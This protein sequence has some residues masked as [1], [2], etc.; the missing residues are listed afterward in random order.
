MAVRSGRDSRRVMDLFAVDKL[1]ASHDAAKAIPLSPNS[2]RALLASRREWLAGLLVGT[3]A[4]SR[5]SPAVG[6]APQGPIARPIESPKLTAAVKL[7]GGVSPLDFEGGDIDTKL[8]QAITHAIERIEVL[9]LRNLPVLEISRPMILS[10]SVARG[11]S[12][13]VAPKS[14]LGGGTHIVARA[15]MRCMVELRNAFGVVL[16][17]L[18]LDGRNQ[19]QMLLDTSWRIS[20]APAMNCRWSDLELRG[21]A[22]RVSWNAD[23]NNDCDFAFIQIQGPTDQPSH[24]AINLECGGGDL[25]LFRVRSYWGK[26]IIAAQSAT[27]T[28]CVT[29]GVVLIGKDFN[30]L[31]IAGGYHYP[32]ADTGMNI[33][34]A[35]RVPVMALS[36]HGAHV[37]NGREGGVVLGGDGLLYGGATFTQCHVFSP[38]GARGVRLLGPSVVGS[39]GPGIR[40]TVR[41]IGGTYQLVD[42]AE[43]AA[44]ALSCEGVNHD[45]VLLSRRRAG[46][47]LR[48]F[49]D[50]DAGLYRHE[51]PAWGPLGAM[52]SASTGE[53]AGGG[54]VRLPL[55]GWP[56]T[57]RLFIRSSDDRCP[58]ATFDYDVTSGTITRIASYGAGQIVARID[59]GTLILSHDIA[60]ATTVF[61]VAAIG[62]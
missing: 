45:Q 48:V 42:L 2:L 17:G 19:A 57:G 9:D 38:G 5:P 21:A 53:C 7:R 33:E 16:Q 10:R 35:G 8:D 34:L 4:A 26:L 29:V 59:A 15:P 41:L 1:R 25:S 13:W 32:A 36:V 51:H 6:A 55:A 58:R 11:E 30:L 37:E 3:V 14:V 31:S 47:A 43:T 62:I 49:E 54:R 22:G 61:L 50:A 23:G 12:N 27:L 44:V 52:R 40:Q 46:G 56:S 39:M 20:G 18:R 60:H 28:N 24:V